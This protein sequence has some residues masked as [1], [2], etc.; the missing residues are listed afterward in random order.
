[1]DL[2]VILLLAAGIILIPSIIMSIVAW[3]DRQ[4]AKKVA[5][6]PTTRYGPVDLPQPQDTY[7]R[8]ISA[9]LVDGR[10]ELIR[11]IR[12]GGMAV[13]TLAIDHHTGS[14]C[15]IKTPRYDID[16]DTKM[17]IQKLEMEAKYLRQ[18]SH[19][20]IVHFVDAFTYRSV[21]HLVVDY[22][23]GQDLFSA[24]SGARAAEPRAIKWGVQILNAL[25]YMADRGIVH[26]DLKPG[27]IMLRKDDDNIVIIDF[28]TVLPV[29]KG[30]GTVVYTTGF[31]IPEQIV[32]RYDTRSDLC[33]LGNTLF[34]LL[35]T[36]QPGDVL[37][38]SFAAVMMEKGVSQNTAKCVAQ[39]MNVDPNQRF[40]RAAAM[41]NALLSTTSKS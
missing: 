10:Y 35:T 2:P 29:G 17:N 25:E 27:N 36:I 8:P 38:G 3:L 5:K 14:Q 16:Q 39:A 21:P 24:F 23:D 40:K 7:S 13:I 4:E 37:N 41:R 1:M 32:G 15:V 33:G 28:G 31:P 12:K 9:E 22:I 18:F 20:N 26:R 6:V 11:Q 34:Y 19:V 30:G